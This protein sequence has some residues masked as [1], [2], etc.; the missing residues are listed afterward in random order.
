MDTRHR[1][2][3]YNYK[4]LIRKQKSKYLLF[5]FR[6]HLLRDTRNTDDTKIEMS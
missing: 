4:T 2:N 5:W 3:S 6:Q 1:Y